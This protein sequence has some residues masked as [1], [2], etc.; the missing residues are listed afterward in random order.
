MRGVAAQSGQTGFTALATARRVVHDTRNFIQLKARWHRVSTRIALPFSSRR[1]C[2]YCAQGRRGDRAPD[3]RL[4]AAMGDTTGMPQLNRNA[5]LF[6]RTPAGFSSMR[7]SVP[8]CE[9]LAAPRITLSLSGN[10]RGFSDDEARACAL[11]RIVFTHQWVGMSPGP[12]LR[13]TGK[14]SHKH[15]VWRSD[16]FST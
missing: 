4:N 2:G 6:R 11:T 9:D 5:A 12:M 14:R 16:G 15:A 8:G 1:T 13:K 3:R 7:R 10:L